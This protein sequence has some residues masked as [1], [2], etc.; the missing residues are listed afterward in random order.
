MANSNSDFENAI[1]DLKELEVSCKMS[2]IILWISCNVKLYNETTSANR[3]RLLT[4]G[5]PNDIGLGS[6]RAIFLD[7][8]EALQELSSI[9]LMEEYFKFE[10]EQYIK[11]KNK[12]SFIDNWLE[13]HSVLVL[14]NLCLFWIEH[15]VEKK[16]IVSPSISNW[17]GDD[18]KIALEEFEGT[19]L[20]L[21]AYYEEYWNRSK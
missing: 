1:T 4:E 6:P 20:F 19:M 7:C 17:K 3:L 10:Y 13:N 18:L 9:Y 16:G 15:I 11:N 2:S 21:N 8:Y 5:L 14:E 12:E